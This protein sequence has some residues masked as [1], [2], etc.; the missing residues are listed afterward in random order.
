MMRREKLWRH[1]G[2]RAC[3][4]LTLCSLLAVPA[5][6]WGRYDTLASGTD[7]ARVARPVVVL[8]DTAA[9]PYRSTKSAPMRL[10]FPTPRRVKS[11]RRP[12]PIGLQRM[13]S[14]TGSPM[15]GD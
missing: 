10:P 14:R 12:W 2:W 6:T 8:T 5:A 3:L 11:T 15:R 13:C 9:G 1:T 7:S 4:L